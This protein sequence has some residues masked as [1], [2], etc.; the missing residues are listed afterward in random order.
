[1]KAFETRFNTPHA[2]FST[3]EHTHHRTRRGALNPFFSRARVLDFVPRFQ[4]HVAR[5]CDRLDR[6]F[7]GQKRVL[8]VSDA[9]VCVTT[10]VILDYAFDVRSRLI[11][12]PDFE[13]QFATAIRDLQRNVHYLTAFPWLVSVLNLVP[14][15]WV[16]NAVPVLRSVFAFRRVSFHITPL[17]CNCPHFHH[18]RTLI[19]T[20]TLDP[21]STHSRVEGASLVA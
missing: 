17:S 1:M 11:D 14:E 5:L 9:L 15:R 18:H 19:R 7:R 4:D 2:T 10:D 3:T 13:D 20:C 12:G 6:D 21:F 8:V 16:E